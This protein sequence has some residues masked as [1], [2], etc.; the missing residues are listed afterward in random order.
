MGDTELGAAVLLVSAEKYLAIVPRRVHAQVDCFPVGHSLHLHLPFHCFRHSFDDR[1]SHRSQF[2]APG[3][4][5]SSSFS[6][7]LTER[8]KMTSSGLA[9]NLLLDFP[10]LPQSPASGRLWEQESE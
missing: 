7:F 2:L 10:I 9:Q 6:C 5:A 8:E 3:K 4:A 1:L